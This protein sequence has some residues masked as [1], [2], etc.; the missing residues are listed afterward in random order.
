MRIHLQS[1][2]ITNTYLDRYGYEFAQ[3]CANTCDID[4]NYLNIRYAIKVRTQAVSTYI[5]EYLHKRLTVRIPIQSVHG[6]MS[7]NAAVRD[8]DTSILTS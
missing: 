6:V 1:L 5:V 2:Y 7:I 4:H 8:N 3:R